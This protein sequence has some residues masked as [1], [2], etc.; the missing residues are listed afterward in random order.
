MPLTDNLITRF[1]AGVSAVPDSDIFAAMRGTDW[2]KA[3]IFTDDFTSLQSYWVVTETQGAATQ[4]ATAGNFGLVLL[5][6]SGAAN[7]VNQ[8]QIAVGSYLPTIASGK[9]LFYKARFQISDVVDSAFACGIQVVNA[10]GT[11]LANAT[12]GMYFLK[13]VGAAT[14]DFYVRQ[15]NVAANSVNAG[16]IATLVNAT[17]VEVAFMY[18]GIDRVFYAVNGVVL[19]S[20]AVTATILPSAVM[21]PIFTL[22][23]GAAAAARTSTLDSAFV[24][25]ER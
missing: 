18:D 25:L 3:Y 21:A 17:Q 10:D 1:P 15:A 6:N 22:K 13:A 4:A 11:V 20:V 5:T 9:R 2:S 19:G 16:A 24:A 14:I 7:D 12:Q 8:L 23:N